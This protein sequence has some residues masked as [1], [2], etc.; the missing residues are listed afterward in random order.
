MRQFMENIKLFRV[1]LEGDPLW[2][3]CEFSDNKPKCN[4]MMKKVR[5]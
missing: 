1:V 3:T 5:E 2:G 4:E